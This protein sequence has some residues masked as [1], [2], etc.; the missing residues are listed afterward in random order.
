[1]NSIHHGSS[2]RFIDSHSHVHREPH[3]VDVS[4]IQNPVSNVAVP[5]LATWRAQ[6]GLVRPKS[7]PAKA[8]PSPV[9]ARSPLTVD[10]STGPT[11]Q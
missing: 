10:Q 5:A 2:L 6:S 3:P 4:P 9:V 1:M 7:S 8:Q 11:C